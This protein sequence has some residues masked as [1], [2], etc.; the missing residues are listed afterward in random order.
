MGALLLA[1]ACNRPSKPVAKVG[2][3]WVGQ[4]Q[5]RAFL[6][7]QPTSMAPQAALD[8]LVRREVAWV[9]AGRTG[10]LQE[11]A[12][13][14]VAPQLRR[15]VVNRFYL[16]ARPGQAPASD[17]AL[18][19][20]F[21]TNGE[22]RHVMHVL[23]ATEAAA[24]AAK[25]RISKGESFEKVA[26]AVSKDPSV[27]ENHGDLGWIR[28]QI[29]VPAFAKPVFEAKAGDL[30]GPLETKFGWHVALV[31]EVR[32]P[33][34]EDF[35]RVREQLRDEAH[36]VVN[37]PKREEA[38]KPLKAK[39]LVNPNP[40]V[41]GLDQTL[42]IAPGDGKRVAGTVGGVEVSLAEIKAFMAESISGGNMQHSLSAATKTRFLD[43]LA[44]EIRL[45]L[46]AE[47]EG[48][49]RRPDVQGAVW[50]LQ[51]KAVYNGFTRNYLRKV[52]IS[53]P[54]LA[55]HLAQHPDRLKSVGAVRVYLLVAKSPVAAAKAIAEGQKGKAWEKL[56]AEFADKDATGNWKPGF[57][58][59]SALKKVLPP[60]AMTALL[61]APLNAIIG[62][63][64][65][66]D[67]SMLFQ[68]LERRPGAVLPLDQCREEVR[69]D[70]LR[71]RGE[72]L[73]NRYLDG[74][75]R[76]GVSIQVFPKNAS[77]QPR[78]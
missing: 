61:N 26:D 78:N 1:P 46:A 21:F 19:A 39:Y 34:Q 65:S 11:D 5:W 13:L 59:V 30:C 12:W 48:L 66:P 35:E 64:E 23:C 16:D 4:P 20:A 51:R 71:T 29:M 40:A 24:A 62:P 18:R 68:V 76:K 63:F 67:G 7:E 31:K 42:T 45:A 41:L 44:D 25:I 8:Q 72:E 3:E 56:V 9:Q 14:A 55:Q 60:E 77:L 74:E 38:L 32:T 22:E 28:A 70:F 17:E 33:K 10:L 50:N 49:A 37:A 47:K 54:D 36:D 58:E 73:V 53:D 75:G 27:L 69:Q 6:A 57:L 52:Q 43:L 15:S 2:G